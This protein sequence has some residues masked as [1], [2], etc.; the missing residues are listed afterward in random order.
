MTY[1][2]IQVHYEWPLNWKPAFHDDLA[3]QANPTGSLDYSESEKQLSIWRY[4][5]ES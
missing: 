2:E 3:Y 5:T 4:G 1:S